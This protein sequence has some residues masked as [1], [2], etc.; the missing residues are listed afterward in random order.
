MPD[1]CQTLPRDGV[2][3]L[4]R[5]STHPVGQGV[6]SVVTDHGFTTVALH[7]HGSIGPHRVLHLVQIQRRR[8]VLPKSES[9]RLLQ[10]GVRHK[11]AIGVV[12]KQSPRRRALLLPFIVGIGDCEGG[13]PCEAIEP[14]PP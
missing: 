14:W 3:A 4:H 7:D 11:L 13:L 1:S 6:V 8:P 12:R 2:D 5:Q 9:P 10:G